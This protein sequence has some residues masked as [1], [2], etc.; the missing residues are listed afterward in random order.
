MALHKSKAFTLSEVLITI[1]IIGIIAAVT[2]PTIMNN[3]KKHEYRS[4]LKKAIAVASNALARH[5]AMTGL[6]ATDYTSSEDIVTEIFKKQTN[7]M[8]TDVE[9]T[10][11]ICSG[12]VFAT[13]DGMIFCVNNFKSESQDLQSGKCNYSNTIPCVETD[14]TANL[15]IDVNG[16]RKPNKITEASIHPNDIYQAQIYSKSVLPF[17]RPTIEVMYGEKYSAVTTSPTTVPTVAP[18]T[19]TTPPAPTTEP[20]PETEPTVEPPTQPTSPTTQPTM[21]TPTSPTDYSGYDPNKWP[22]FYD[23]LKWLFGLFGINLP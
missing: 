16:E 11:E 8:D 14:D 15:W 18:T 2:L 9:F 22:S 23:F 5:Y 17:G 21:P 13:T 1:V 7:T 19:P 3:T 6:T 12:A 4:A 10:S 20:E